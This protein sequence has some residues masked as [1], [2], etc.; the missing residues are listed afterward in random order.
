MS[1][2]VFFFGLAMTAVALVFTLTDH[3]VS[4]LGAGITQA[5]MPDSDG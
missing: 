5:I 3:I 4:V 1:K 2:R